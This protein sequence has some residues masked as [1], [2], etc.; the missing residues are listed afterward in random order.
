MFKREKV[1]DVCGYPSRKGIKMAGFGKKRQFVCEKCE[2]AMKLMILQI[3]RRK[4][5]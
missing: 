5:V 1:C 3:R 2:N 4:G